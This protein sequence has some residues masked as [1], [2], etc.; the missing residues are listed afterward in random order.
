VTSAVISLTISAVAFAISVASVYW[1]V[2]LRR[3]N[4]QLMESN[5]RLAARI[6]ELS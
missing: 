6:K 1:N 2:R 3:T 5:Q 4:Q